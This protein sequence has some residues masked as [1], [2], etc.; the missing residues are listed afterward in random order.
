MAMDMVERVL[1]ERRL[2]NYDESSDW[3][4][5]IGSTCDEEKGSKTEDKGKKDEG[6]K[7]A[8]SVFDAKGCSKSGC[9]PS[10]YLLGTQKA[11]STSFFEFLEAQGLAC[12]AHYRADKG[13]IEP[14]NS[15]EVHAFDSKWEKSLVSDPSPYVKL[16]QSADCN[17]GQFMDA[18]P[19]YLFTWESP[20]RLVASVPKAWRPELRF[21]TIFRE[22][23]SRDLSW[24]N[25][26]LMDEGYPFCEDQALGGFS[27]EAPK[28]TGLQFTARRESP[29]FG[30]GH[31][32]TYASEAECT[33]KNFLKGC[34][35][36]K[37]DGKELAHEEEVEVLALG[38]TK[39][40]EDEG[41]LAGQLYAQNRACIRSENWGGF[42]SW[43]FYAAHL[44][45]WAQFV[46]RK[47]I[48]VFE[49]D[50][51]LSD[52]PN[53]IRAAIDFF[54]L[55]AS[56]IKDTA[57]LPHE[58]THE[59]S[60]KLE[61]AECATLDMLNAVF[62]PW[63]ELL[64]ASLETSKKNGESPK[65][66]PDFP[67]W[68]TPACTNTVQ[69]RPDGSPDAGGAEGAD[70]WEEPGSTWQEPVAASAQSEST[71][72]GDWCAAD[73]AQWEEK[74]QWDSCHG[75][76]DCGGAKT[77]VAQISGGSNDGAAS[78]KP[79][80][81]GNGWS[82]ELL[83]GK[84]HP[85]NPLRYLK[86]TPRIVFG[87]AT[88]HELVDT[89][90]RAQRDTW[91]SDL[92]A[93]IWFS[94]QRK[95]STG[96]DDK[97]EGPAT[98]AVLLDEFGFD[99]E[100]LKSREVYQNAQLRFMPILYL[101]KQAIEGDF[102]RH[103][104]DV[105]W[106]VVAD[107][108]TYVFYDNLLS[109]L[110]ILDHTKPVYTGNV[111]PESWFPLRMDEDGHDLGVETSTKFVNGGAGSFI[112]LKGL[113]AMDMAGCLESSK[114]EWWKMQSDWMIGLCTARAGFGPTELDAGIFNSFACTDN[115]SHVYVCKD[116]YGDYKDGRYLTQ[117]ATIHPVK[118]PKVLELLWKQYPRSRTKPA[119]NITTKADARTG[120]RV[121]TQGELE[122]AGELRVIGE[123]RTRT[124]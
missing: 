57:R 55:P 67:R 95:N 7:D 54:G 113:L 97:H 47:Q 89:R 83:L 101:M 75:C 121:M 72:C 81:I 35:A 3:E 108:D 41:S 31:G 32:P 48:M 4:P 6:M 103:F 90:A 28:P 110:H 105:Q 17:S 13:A 63:N 25:H 65:G 23:I 76:N 122:M 92:G 53:H 115:A 34:M 56:A 27:I 91:C 21:L 119:Y 15:K 109:A 61:L 33:I 30:A 37:T 104:S 73:G 22:P 62:Q 116:K 112:S 42:L 94:D 38:G 12:G 26:R 9:W 8:S 98:K 87:I 2:D 114:H 36:V 88:G 29:N 99:R 64:Y 68:N 44:R 74:C 18:T 106:V 46:P 100:T 5:K 117:P 59:S 70:S 16:Y 120:L 60:A 123:L 71:Q 66:E 78:D 102:Y 49:F 14:L 82:T 84:S 20:Q 111:S 45:R 39:A 124:P 24:Y 69:S 79:V 19:N 85:T 96:K 51:M 52:T 1:N 80:D 93:C 10:M 58:N 107:D 40:D 77:D 118:D 43:G 11:A 50:Q 86:G